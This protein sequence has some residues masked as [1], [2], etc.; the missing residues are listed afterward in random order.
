MACGWVYSPHD[1]SCKYTYSI[2]FYYILF[3][4]LNPIVSIFQTL[5]TGLSIIKNC[6]WSTLLRLM[7]VRFFAPVLLLTIFT[8]ELGVN[9]MSAL[10]L[11][12]S[13]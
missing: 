11:H 3:Y 10:K 8:L 6:T 12:C 4:L 7:R 5:K 9:G 1:G 2:L 13:S